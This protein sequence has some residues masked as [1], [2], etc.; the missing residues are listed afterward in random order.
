MTRPTWLDALVGREL[1]AVLEVEVHFP[2]EAP[3]TTG[4][5]VLETDRGWLQLVATAADRRLHAMTTPSDVALVGDWSDRSGIV[6]L[7]TDAVDVA[8]HVRRVD[9]AQ[10]GDG[11]DAASSVGAWLVGDGDAVRR[12]I[13]VDGEDAR[14]GPPEVL[15]TFLRT[16]THHTART[17]LH[18]RR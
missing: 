1:R 9:Y 6:L 3:L 16:A 18:G 14:I 17:V 7:P 10:R 8:F 2:S 5:L 15:W 12:A 11:T 4:D 13:L